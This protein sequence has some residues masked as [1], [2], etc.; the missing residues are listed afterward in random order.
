MKHTATACALASWILAASCSAKPAEHLTPATDPSTQATASHAVAPA[1]PVA[2]G[3][4]QTVQGQVLETM[5]G[6][7]YTYVRVKTPQGDI[8]A[9][10]LAF[11]VA[12]GDTVIVPLENPMRNFKSQALNRQFDL[13][14]LR[15]QHHQAG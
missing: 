7:N 3:A 9:A 5:D 15:V 6:S 8:W 1:D 12:V 2:A 4:G 13:V 14:V 11:K 10:T